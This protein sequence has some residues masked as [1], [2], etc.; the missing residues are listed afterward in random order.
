MGIFTVGFRLLA[1]PNASSELTAI[2]FSLS[3]EMD[4]A[5]KDPGTVL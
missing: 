5:V 2:A 1:D 3:I 4:L